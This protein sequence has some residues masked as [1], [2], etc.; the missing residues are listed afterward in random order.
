MVHFCFPN[1]RSRGGQDHD[2]GFAMTA[3][4]IARLY[5]RLSRY[6]SGAGK[7]WGVG[8][9]RAGGLAGIRQGVREGA[10]ASG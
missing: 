10:A 4:R 8:T 2:H 1:A 6:I 5:Q 3:Q 9:G 7:D